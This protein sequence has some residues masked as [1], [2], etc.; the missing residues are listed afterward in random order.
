ML[1]R[2][3]LTARGL[4]PRAGFV[5]Y[6]FPFPRPP[7]RRPH[8]YP[9]SLRRCVRHQR[10]REHRGPGRQHAAAAENAIAGPACGSCPVACGGCVPGACG[11]AG[12]CHRVGHRDTSRGKARLATHGTRT[13]ARPCPSLDAAPSH[14]CLHVESR[15]HG[16]GGTP[17]PAQHSA[18]LLTP[19]NAPFPAHSVSR[20]RQTATHRPPTSCSRCAPAQLGPLGQCAWWGTGRCGPRGP[21]RTPPWPERRPTRWPHCCSRGAVGRGAPPTMA[22]ARRRSPPPK[23]TQV[24]GT[25]ST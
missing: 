6:P 20:A 12:M 14:A 15:A 23:L 5:L 18:A 2:R 13:F 16:G 10:A 17:L 22:Y 24:R 25:L 7:P 4:T 8:A 9:R 21:G 1:C 3:A 11:A 19:T